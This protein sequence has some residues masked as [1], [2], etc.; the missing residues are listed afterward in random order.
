M[1]IYPNPAQDYITVDIS[2][3]N[4][5]LSIDII[6]SLGQTVKKSEITSGSTSSSIDVQNM[7]KGIYFLRI[8]NTKDFKSF[9]VLIE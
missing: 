3:N 4:E 5:N 8:S 9:K 6:N 7:S 1:K 2:L